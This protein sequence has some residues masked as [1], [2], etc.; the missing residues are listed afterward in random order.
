MTGG[1]VKTVTLLQQLVRSV[2]ASDVI[3]VYIY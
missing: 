3:A 2:D 1:A